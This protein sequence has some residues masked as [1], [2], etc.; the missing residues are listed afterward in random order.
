MTPRLT[1]LLQLLLSAPR[2]VMVAELARRCGCSER[3]VFRELRTVATLAAGVGLELVTRPGLGVALAGDA[4]TKAYWSRQICGSVALPVGVAQRRDWLLVA[5]LTG[6]RVVKLAGLARRLGVSGA[7][8]SHDLDALESVLDAAGLSLE[9]RP[10][11]GATVTGAESGVRALLEARLACAANNRIG[12]YP[13]GPIAEAVAGLMTSRFA[14]GVDQLTPESAASL[15]RHLIVLVERVGARGARARHDGVNDPPDDQ[16]ADVPTTNEEG[17]SRCSSDP[18]DVAATATDAGPTD[19]TAP[20][21]E[22]TA[23]RLASGSCD[24]PNESAVLADY[25]IDSLELAFGLELG[26]ERAGLATFVAALRRRDGLV[27]APRHLA[28]QLIEQFD[29]ANS[30]LLKQDDRLIA[31]L[32]AH[33]ASAAPRIRGRIE[34]VDPLHD[35]MTRAYPDAVARSAAALAALF[36]GQAIPASE[37]TFLATHFGAAQIRLRQWAGRPWRVAVVCDVGIGSSYLMASQ[38]TSHFAGRIVVEVL[39]TSDIADW[40]DFDLCVSSVELAAPLGPVVAAHPVLTPNDLLAVAAQLEALD[41]SVTPPHLTATLQS[42]TRFGVTWSR[43]HRLIDWALAI[44]D[45]LAVI[46]VPAQSTVASLAGE[47]GYRYGA[48]ATA[49]RAICQAIIDRQNLSSLAIEALEL[50]LLHVRSDAVVRPIVAL[51]QPVG[52]RFDSLELQGLRSGLL[53]LAPQDAD[54]DDLA[55]LGRISAALIDRPDFLEAV[56]QGSLDAVRRTIEDLFTNCLTQL[57]TSR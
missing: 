1:Q 52:G 34:L 22:P 26:V 12:A 51:I 23:G 56:H 36:P 54:S 16:S 7:T 11:F 29:Q 42:A 27:M 15:T 45:G 14:G 24:Q 18:K 33:L 3:T 9:R 2:E 25:I 47:A 32:T 57:I 35:E 5:L 6:A 49:G 50:L 10:G 39:P 30:Y 55:L 21:G 38:L 37:A 13:P 53:M 41:S 48:E 46:T 4:A 43:R 44:V 40:D 8:V 20:A 28:Y 19:G 17:H 31:G